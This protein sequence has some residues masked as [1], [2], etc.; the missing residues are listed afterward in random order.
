M[1]LINSR[2]RRATVAKKSAESPKP[3][4]SKSGR[5]VPVVVGAETAPL[6]FANAVLNF[7]ATG[8]VANF[9]LATRRDTTATDG[10]NVPQLYITG[11]LRIPVADLPGFRRIIDKILLMV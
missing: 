7:G 4:V 8:A 1:N 11:D 2:A 5:T 3:A 9:L 10:A 6:I